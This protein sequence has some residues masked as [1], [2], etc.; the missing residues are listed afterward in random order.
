MWYYLVRM[1]SWSKFIDRS[2]KS[3]LIAISFKEYNTGDLSQYESVESLKETFNSEISNNKIWIQAWQMYRFSNEIQTWDIVI[4]PLGDW[5]YLVWKAWEYF[6]DNDSE[7]LTNYKHRRKIS[8]FSEIIR[9]WDMSTNL[10]YSLWATLTIFSLNKYWEELQNLIDGSD[11][12][13]ADKPQRVR[14]CIIDGL[15]QFDWKE[16]EIFIKHLLTLIWFEAEETPYV[17]DKG[18]DIVGIL[19]ADWLANI[20]LKIQAKRYESQKISNDVVLQLRWTLKTD[21]HWCIITTSSFTWPAIECSTE[22]WLKPIKL[23]DGYD[24]A[25]IILTHYD[26]LDPSYKD[27]FSIRRKI[28]Y[29][30]EEQFEITDW[31]LWEENTDIITNSV[32]SEQWVIDT[33]VCAAKEDGFK[34]AFLEKKARWAIRISKDK[35]DSIKYLA[36]YQVAPISQITHYWK[37]QS[38]EKYNDTD[39]YIVYFSSIHKLK[40]S[41]WLDG[42]KHLKPQWPRYCTY[43]KLLSAQSL[44][45]LFW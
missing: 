27:I 42:N 1:W 43:K 35:I 20:Q 22:E 5:E 44:G 10:S 8:W 17:W 40:V 26:N 21:E 3:G 9:K 14:D 16:F 19:H 18:V 39:K 31:I 29:N 15:L 13:P 7:E 23:V 2:K 33:L 6:F 11:Y 34:S 28:E 24:L 32:S 37:I 25:S 36:I 30:I 12:T 38:I 45:Q 41:I 4:S